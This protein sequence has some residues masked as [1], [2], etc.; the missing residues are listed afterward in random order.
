MSSAAILMSALVLDAVAGEPRPLWSRVPHPAV[1]LGRAIAWADT[2]LNTGA[3]L[4]AKGLLF[5]IGLAIIAGFAGLILQELGSLVEILVVAILLAHRSLM[6]HVGAVARDLRLS[7]GDGRRA[8]AMI[9]GRDTTN[10]QP[11]EIARAAIESAAENFSDGVIAPAFWFLL[12]G[13]PGIVIYKA[14]NTA[15][16]M[17]G[18]LTPRHAEFGWASARLDDLLNWVPARLTALL[19][20]LTGGQMKAWSHI[21]TE[22]RLHRSPNAGWPE[23]ALA[24]SLDVALSGPRSYDGIAGEYPFVHSAG[25][26]D[27]GPVEIEAS[28]RA[29]WIGWGAFMAFCAFLAI[30]TI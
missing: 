4:R 24:R 22:A 14:V 10:M 1:L 25:N 11:P 20:A 30:V 23:A 3:F 9:V 8:V 13:L 6:D 5:L 21:S 7:T 17:V 28:T 19:L 12:A 16:S 15:D 29:L 27:I 18:Y 2:K 26:R